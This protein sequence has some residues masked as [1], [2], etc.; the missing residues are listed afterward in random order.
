MYREKADALISYRA[1]KLQPPWFFSCA[2]GTYHSKVLTGKQTPKMILFSTASIYVKLCIYSEVS[3]CYKEVKH[4]HNIV[5]CSKVIQRFLPSAS[6][7]RCGSRDQFR[8]VS[9]WDTT[10][11]ETDLCSRC[12][13]LSATVILSPFTPAHWAP[14]R[15]TPKS[16]F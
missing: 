7:R 10:D 14:T 4:K 8:S 15:S 1:S 9:P 12:P 11:L 5:F 13:W 3:V 2:D 6:K 16:G